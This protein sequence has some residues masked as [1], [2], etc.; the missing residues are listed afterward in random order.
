[1]TKQKHNK[2]C[3]FCSYGKNKKQHR[4]QSGKYALLKSNIYTTGMTKKK[5]IVNVIPES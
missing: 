2:I 1:M 5:T 4:H 3:N